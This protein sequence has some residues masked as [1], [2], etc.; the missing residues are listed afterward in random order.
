MTD[1]M[2]N[3]SHPSPLRLQTCARVR[4]AYARG[5]VHVS[6]VCEGGGFFSDRRPESA[7]P[8]SETVRPKGAPAVASPWA[9]F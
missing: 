5:E 4:A 1:E 9:G 8:V 3:V 2:M 6:V 7:L